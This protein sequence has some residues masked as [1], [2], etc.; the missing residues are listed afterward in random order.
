M[1]SLNDKQIREH[2][3][4]KLSRQPVQPKAIIEELRIHNGN[5]IADVVALY[6]DA[7]CFEIK[8]DLD[9]IERVVDQGKYYD[10]SFRKITLVTTRKHIKKA[11]SLAPHHWGIILAEEKHDSISFRTVRSAVTNSS[12]D[13]ERALMTLW[14]REMLSL[15]DQENRKNKTKSR[16]WL[17]NL[18]S[19]CHRKEE[20]SSNI[21]ELLL[22]RYQSSS[23]A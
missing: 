3:I 17:A 11:L 2:L 23:T 19:N 20:V 9:K 4:E 22:S 16:E 21:T 14:K 15:V 6:R 8:S 12:F 13:K 1:S 5:A 7:H 18:I 10:L